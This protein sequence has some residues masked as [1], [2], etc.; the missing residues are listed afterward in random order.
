MFAASLALTALPATASAGNVGVKGDRLVVNTATTA[1]ELVI[2][3]AANRLRVEEHNG[4]GGLATSS[5]RCTRE[6]VE[7]FI[8]VECPAKG[9]REVVVSTRGGNDW[10]VVGRDL[11][12]SRGDRNHCS[13]SRVGAPLTVDL[14]AGNDIAELGAGADRVRGQG[15]HDLLMGCAG[16]D[17]V[18]GGPQGDDLSGDRGN[19]RLRGEGGSDKLVGCSY[20]PDDVNYPRDENGEDNLDGGADDDFLIGCNGL[21]AFAA[22][23]GDDDLNVRDGLGE[24]ADCGEGN[25][26]IYLDPED[27]RPSCET[28]TDCVTDNYPIGPE[29]GAPECFTASRQ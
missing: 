21:D 17:L 24:V 13:A 18:R 23:D 22:G 25:D 19:D 8:R 11:P 7:D 12:D 10:V 1:N 20:D 2:G 26:V 29:T 14:G 27:S 6:V 15:G 3:L 4:N 9:V 16:D 5:P 28:V